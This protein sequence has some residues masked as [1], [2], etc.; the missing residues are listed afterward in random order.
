LIGFD[1]AFRAAFV[2]GLRL[3]AAPERGNYVMAWEDGTSRY[4][5]PSRDE[6]QGH[7]LASSTIR[8]IRK[9]NGER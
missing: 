5:R 6:D 2:H 3:R 1:R 9:S 4:N 7:V 8:I